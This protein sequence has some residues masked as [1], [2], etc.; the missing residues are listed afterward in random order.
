M[1][2]QNKSERQLIAL[3]FDYYRDQGRLLEQFFSR[4]NTVKLPFNLLEQLRRHDYPGYP[5]FECGLPSTYYYYLRDSGWG[6]NRPFPENPLHT[7]FVYS[8]DGLGLNFGCPLRLKRAIEILFNLPEEDQVEC[9]TNLAQSSKHLSTIEEILWLDVWRR[10]SRISRSEGQPNKTHDWIISFNEFSVRVECKFR[11]FDW[12]RLVDGSAF[13]PAGDFLAGKASKQLPNPPET[14][15]INIVC[16]TGIARVDDDFRRVCAN[17]LRTYPNVQVL[18]YRTLVGETTVFSMTENMAKLVH[19][20]VAPQPA[21]AFQPAYSIFYNRKEKKRRD[22]ARAAG[23]ITRRTDMSVPLSE[24]PVASLSP[25]KRYL[26]PPIPYRYTLERRLDSGEPVFKSVAPYLPA[27][28][29]RPH[30]AL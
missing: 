6:S 3:F 18:V 9:R 7:E 30:D 2:G 28:A 25:Q 5:T 14:G 24:M 21:D 8:T 1:F 13:T 27:R 12:A 26:E 16:V 10:P 15:S 20:L 23:P 17:E 29:G 11:P 22:D 19:G 4:V